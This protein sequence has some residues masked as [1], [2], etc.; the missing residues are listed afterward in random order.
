MLRENI[1]SDDL[2]YLIEL[3]K[4]M[5]NMLTQNVQPMAGTVIHTHM[6]GPIILIAFIQ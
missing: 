6:N 2:N 3:K 5:Y 4:K 1:I